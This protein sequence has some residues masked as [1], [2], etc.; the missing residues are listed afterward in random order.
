[1]GKNQYGQLG[2][3]STVDQN[4]SV[5]IE[6]NDVTAVVAGFDHSHYIRAGSL[7]A[8]GRNQYRQLGD[9]SS[10]DRNASVVV[11]ASGVSDIF[12][13]SSGNQSFYLK[14]DGSLWGMG[15]NHLGQLGD[16]TVSDPL[17][18][19]QVGKT[20]VLNVVGSGTVTGGGSYFSGENISVTATPAAGYLFNGWSGDSNS[21]SSPLNLSVM[22][23]LEINATF[24]QQ[25]ALQYV[26]ANPANYNL[27][28]E[29][30]KNASDA[31]QFA[32]G[33]T[34][35][36]GEGNASGIAHVQANPSLYNLYTESEKNASDTTQFT[37]G[38]IAGIVEGNTYGMAQVQ[39]NPSDYNLYTESEKNASDT[40]QFANGKTAGIIEGNASGVGYVQANPSLY[41]LYTESQKSASDA[42]QFAN[43]KIAGIAE[44]NASGIAYVQGN[45]SF[46]NLYTESDRNA[47]LNLAKEAG[48]TEGLATVQADLASQGLALLGYVN[49]M[50]ATKL[51]TDEWHYQPGMGWLWTS[52][53]VFPFFYRAEEGQSPAGWLYFGQLPTQLNASFYDYSTSTWIHPNDS[54]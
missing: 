24:F 4:T 41:N 11:L 28:T 46:F 38:K 32:N 30:E 1:M 20:V 26:Q 21:S 3:G 43:G 17:S 13:S 42:S 5:Q 34:A 16:G 25:A 9:N 36:I 39:E 2:I 48:K 18:P 53:N 14:T 54:P 35:G 51:Y 33:K 29:A 12:S 50:N 44:G 7:R 6:A 27:F 8:M 31:T 47:S 22:N 19:V 49:E 40:T 52:D 45:P 23:Q 10:T 15:R 37:N